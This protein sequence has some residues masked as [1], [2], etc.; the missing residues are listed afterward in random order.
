MDDQSRD[1]LAFRSEGRF[2]SQH[3]LGRRGDLAARRL[4]AQGSECPGRD[5][6]LLANLP[7]PEK[8]VLPGEMARIRRRLG[9][10]LET[11]APMEG[12]GVALRRASEVESARGALR[13]PDQGA[14]RTF[15]P[16]PILPGLIY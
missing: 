10:L 1:L 4:L 7:K 14:A 2:A 16:H 3:L 6:I 9:R 15:S 5:G 12:R 8:A 13:G 11:R